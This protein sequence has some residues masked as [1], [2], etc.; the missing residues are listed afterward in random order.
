MASFRCGNIL[1]KE[2]S[3]TQKLIKIFGENGWSDLEDLTKLTAYL[4]HKK[5]DQFL[6]W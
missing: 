1:Q 5:Y 6:I 3:K 2:T 4:P